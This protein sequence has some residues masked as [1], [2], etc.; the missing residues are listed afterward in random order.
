MCSWGNEGEDFSRET[1]AF[2]V[3]FRLKAE[4]VG[5]AS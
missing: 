2:K 1:L 4:V 5:G 3:G